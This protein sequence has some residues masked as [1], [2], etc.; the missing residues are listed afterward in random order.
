MHTKQGEATQ[1][2][3]VLQPIFPEVHR[4]NIQTWDVRIVLFGIAQFAA[5][6]CREYTRPVEC[7]RAL[8]TV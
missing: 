5:D 2:R 4:A 1:N 3:N 8:R 6:P 7:E